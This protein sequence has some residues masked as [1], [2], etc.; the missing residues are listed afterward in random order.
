M[1]FSELDPIIFKKPRTIERE[2]AWIEHIPFAFFTAKSLKPDVFVELGTHYGTS[3]FAFCEVLKEL[4]HKAKCYAVDHWKGDSQ[5]GYFTESV[6]DYVN[7]VNEKYYSDFSTL[8]KMPFDDA[9]N[10]FDDATIDLL[11][12]DGLHDYESVKNDF[13]N[14]L[15]KMSENGVVLLHDT[16]VK[17]SDFGVW[18][19][20]EEL[21]N[22][23]KNFEFSFGYGLGIVC[24]GKEIPNSFETVIDDQNSEKII[25]ELFRAIGKLRLEEFKN[26]TLKNHQVDVNRFEAQIFYKDPDESFG[27]KKSKTFHV[28]EKIER[29]SVD[30]PEPIGINN[31][32]F[33]PLNGYAD[34]T[35]NSVQFRQREKTKNLNFKISSNA[36][37]KYKNR[38][39]FDTED[40]Q[41]YFKSKSLISPK[42]NG[43]D[44][45]IT[46]H[47]KGIK[48]LENVIKYL[49]RK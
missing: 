17:S 38:F 18:K 39:I 24:T 47:Q 48:T 40:P 16:Q 43:I 20:F 23:Y 21:K 32:R 29:I 10:H 3:Y 33:D 45:E 9:L 14:W 8:L 22:V 26:K 7:Q 6:Y 41:I 44:I 15:P 5:A 11:H 46:F 31:I 12:I 42:V 25:H 30:F 37:Y 49:K 4:P 34:V 28:A 1:R 13:Y 2:S 19:L 27:E 35:L 36:V